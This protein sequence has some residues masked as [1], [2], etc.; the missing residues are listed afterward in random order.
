M[1][2]DRLRRAWSAL[3]ELHLRDAQAGYGVLTMAAL[4]W[5]WGFL[6]ALFLTAVL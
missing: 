4:L 5:L 3:L 2:L 6:A 1:I